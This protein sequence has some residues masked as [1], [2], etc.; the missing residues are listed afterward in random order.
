MV[1]GHAAAG[2]PFG[3]VAGGRS[4][5]AQQQLAGQVRGGG[6]GICVRCPARLQDPAFPPGAR[7]PGVPW[8]GWS[9][10]ARGRPARGARLQGPPGLPLGLGGD[11]LAAALGADPPPRRRPPGLAFFYCHAAGGRPVSL[12]SA[13]RRHRE[14]DGRWKSVTQQ[15]KGQ[16][17]LDQHQV[18]ALALLPPSRRAV[19]VALACWPSPPPAPAPPGGAPPPPA[20][21]SPRPGATPGKCPPAPTTSLPAR[22]RPGQGQRPRGPPPAPPGHHAHDRRRPRARLRLVPLAATPPGPR[23]IAPLPGPAPSLPGM[24][25]DQATD[26]DCSTGGWQCRP[27]CGPRRSRKTVDLAGY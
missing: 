22:P 9:P 26:R 15:A 6:Q 27:A 24:S 2:T 13:D 10:R 3:W 23:P 17:R 18:R 7:S 14:G 16:A 1:A 5:R 25:H 4:L 11:G 19:D 12:S 8:P 20:A 21:A